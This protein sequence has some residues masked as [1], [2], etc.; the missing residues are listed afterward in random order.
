MDALAFDPVYLTIA[1][2]SA[3]IG[4]FVGVL[5][6]WLIGKSRNKRMAEERELAFELANA[7]LTQA[8]S[9]ISNRSLQANSD[10]FLK[11][12]EQKLENQ[13]EKAKQLIKKISLRRTNSVLMR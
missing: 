2:P 11:L 6:T 4:L 8:F 9:D 1:L 5:V 10:T 7:K 12:A 3:A 13:Q